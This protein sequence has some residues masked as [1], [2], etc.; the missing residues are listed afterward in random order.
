LLLESYS[1]SF[2]LS[3]ILP[4]LSRDVGRNLVVPTLPDPELKTST[5]FYPP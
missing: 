1:K 3:R 4:V 5:E 2:A